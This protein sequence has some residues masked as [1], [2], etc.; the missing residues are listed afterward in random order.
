MELRVLIMGLAVLAGG[1]ARAEPQFGLGPDGIFLGTRESGFQ[2]RLRSLIQA[3]SRF[4]LNHA[5]R[6]NDTFRI[7]RA[8]LYVEGTV[9]DF[10]DYRLMPDFAGSQVQLLD[11]WIN[12]R[13]WS[14]LQ[15]RGGKFK[16][17]SSLEF[18][19]Q[20]SAGVFLDRS[21]VTVLA[22]DRDVGVGLHGDWARMLQWDVALL[23]G[24]PDG[25]SVDLDHDFGKALVARLFVHPLRP[26]HRPFLDRFGLGMA[27]SY[28]KET[29]RPGSTGLS[30]LRTPGQLIFF[31]WRVDPQGIAT[32][33]A[34]GTRYRLNPQLYYYAGPVG[35]LAEYIYSSTDVSSGAARSTV[36]NQAW[37][38]QVA[39]VLTLEP[40]SYE[41][42]VP[43]R[44]FS[45]AKRQ[46]GAFELGA[47][48][49]QLRVGSAA[50]PTFA[51]PERSARRAL[52]WGLE[53]N[54]YLTRNLRL[55]I[56]YERTVFDGGATAMGD[57]VPEDVLL[58]R[59][60]L[61]L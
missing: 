27:G 24:A 19:Q 16:T 49:H 30:N 50:F 52:A 13:P 44:P 33:F 54:W 36:A 61:A 20:D 2:L 10:I 28:S 37:N 7:R 53:A 59:L 17:P 34:N 55:G 11:A 15:L 8:R 29:G 26:L 9:G 57:R 41:G 58:S 21:L 25:A 45:I 48:V 46:L 39:V 35:L 43:N 18:L 47:R 40:A 1:A 32:V 3:E 31:S 60:Q 14:W 22:P 5:V 4:Y 56:M 12:L 51:D 23:N 42:V 38:V 6:I